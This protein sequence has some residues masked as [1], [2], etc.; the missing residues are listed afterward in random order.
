MIHTLS[1]LAKTNPAPSTGSPACLRGADS[2]LKAWRWPHRTGR[3][4]QAHRVVAGD[5][6]ALEQMTKQ[7]HKLVNA[8]Q[9][10]DLSGMLLLSAS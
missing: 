9:V 4:L 5:D 3:R 7:L 1:V 10:I 2:I 8:L 6:N